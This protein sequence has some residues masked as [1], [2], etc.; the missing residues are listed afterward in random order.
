MTKTKTSYEMVKEF[1]QKFGHPVET[2]PLTPSV[3]IMKF[4]ARFLLEEVSEHI[5]A[6]GARKGRNQHLARSVEL[7]ELA[8]NQI[9][10]AQD[11]EFDDVDMIE[12]ADS[13]GDLDYIVNGAALV[14]GIPLPAVVAE[15]HA[16][17]MT[18]LGKDGKPIHNEEGK[19]VKGPGYRPPSLASILYPE[20]ESVKESTQ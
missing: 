14:Y 10:L 8:A 9:A 13:L 16:S 12:V 2:T 18:K 20:D 19:V 6:L 11:Y 17:N 15:I 5:L 4:R 1:H 3:K 7:L